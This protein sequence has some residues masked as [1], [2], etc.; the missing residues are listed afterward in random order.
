MSYFT[1]SASTIEGDAV[2]NAQAENLGHIEDIMLDVETG[3]VAYAVLSFGGFL[4]MGN[5]LFAVPWQALQLDRENHRFILDVDKA[6]LENAPGFDKD[7][8]PDAADQ[9]FLTAIYDYYHAP[10][11]R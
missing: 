1:L 11:F 9:E 2:V 5:K 8:W 6:R 3:R 10:A 4:G 7:N